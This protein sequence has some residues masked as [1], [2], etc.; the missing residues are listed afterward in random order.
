[1]AAALPWK[2]GPEFKQAL[3]SSSRMVAI[4]ALQRDIGSGSVTGKNN[5][6]D[7]VV[8]YVPDARDEKNI[9]EGLKGA[10]DILR[11]CDSVERIWTCH[12]DQPYYDVPSGG[13]KGSAGEVALEMRTST[14]QRSL[15][16]FVPLS[17]RPSQR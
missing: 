9:K 17:S 12:V 3:E 4:I 2:N 6:F 7:P 10:F 11:A 15:I 13:D 8:D 14:L 1:M 16:C 5:G